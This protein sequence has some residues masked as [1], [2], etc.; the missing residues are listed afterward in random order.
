MKFYAFCVWRCDSYV[1]N[2]CSPSGRGILLVKMQK[3]KDSRNRD[4]GFQTL[5]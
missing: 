5:A 2:G 1:T 3:G 4:P